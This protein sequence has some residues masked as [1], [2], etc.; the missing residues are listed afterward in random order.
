MKGV[1][2]IMLSR[3][4][5]FSHVGEEQIYDRKDDFEED[6]LLYMLEA[7]SRKP[8]GLLDRLVYIWKVHVLGENAD[9]GINRVSA[10]ILITPPHKDAYWQELDVTLVPPIIRYRN[11]TDG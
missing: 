8:F 3:G 11:K 7:E 10:F 1:Y 9:F 2:K 6:L 4:T 5:L